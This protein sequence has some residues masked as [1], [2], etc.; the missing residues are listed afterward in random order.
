MATVAAVDKPYLRPIDGVC[1]PSTTPRVL[2]IISYVVARLV[3]RNDNLVDD[4]YVD[5]WE[6]ESGNKKS[7]AVFNGVKAPAIRIPKYLER[8]YKYTD[9]SP[10][11]FVVAYAYVDRLLHKHPHCLVVS[12]NVHRL[13][14]TC[15]MVASKILDDE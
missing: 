14:V 15:V 8:I 1:D 13:L 2:T 9:C 7:L 11:C 6:L 12:R 5:E 10:S 3:A 4:G